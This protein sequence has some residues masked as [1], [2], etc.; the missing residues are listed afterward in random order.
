MPYEDAKPSQQQSEQIVKLRE[1]LSKFETEEGR[2]L[3]L[4]YVPKSVDEVIITTSPK[5]G[6]CFKIFD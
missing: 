6:K 5:A 4:S 1:R 3:G 2:L